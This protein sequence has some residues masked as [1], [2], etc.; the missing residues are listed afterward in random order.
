MRSLLFAAALLFF[1]QTSAAEKDFRGFVKVD[2]GVQLYVDWKKAEPGRPTVVLINGITYSTTQWSHFAEALGEQGF[3]VLRYDPQGMGQTLLKYAPILKQ[4]P[5]QDQIRDLHSL[6]ENLKVKKPYNIL[7]LSYGGG[8]G[9]GFAAKYPQEVQ[10]LIAMAPFTEPIRS[11]EQWVRSQVWLTRQTQPWNFSTD[12]QL[13]E[14]FYR[15]LVYSAYPVA[16]PI[17]LEN[18]FKL[19]A[20]YELALGIR[21]FVVHKVVENLPKHSFHLIIAGH[22]EYIEREVLESFWEKTPKSV[23]ATK[24]II[25]GSHHKIPEEEPHFAAA[26]VAKI[27]EDSPVFVA[28]RSFE[29]DPSTGLIKYEDGSFRLPKER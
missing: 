11:Q 27:L 10:K 4:I 19:E 20:I 15:Q 22:D 1:F 14:Y 12:E 7:G 24:T 13:Y 3:G 8:V 2:S 23:R 28:G 26:Y 17:V 9:I 5:Y 21:K 18:P 16:E 25:L 29:A 6:L